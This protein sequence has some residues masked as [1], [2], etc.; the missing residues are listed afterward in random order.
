MTSDY[1]SYHSDKTSCCYSRCSWIILHDQLGFSIEM[2]LLSLLSH[3]QL[4]SSCFDKLEQVGSF[5]FHSPDVSVGKDAR[6]IL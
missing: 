5:S 6:A 4:L 1:F 2:G 3:L